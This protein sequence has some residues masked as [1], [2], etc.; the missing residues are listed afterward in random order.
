MHA[1]HG[2][3]VVGDDEETGFSALKHGIKQ[4]AEAF[5]IVIIQRRVNFVEHAD[6]RWVGEEHREN[7]RERCQCLFTT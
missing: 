2:E 3:G 5:H 4:I 6:R 1:G 7:Q